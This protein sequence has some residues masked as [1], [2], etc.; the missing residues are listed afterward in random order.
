MSSRY[1]NRKR[2]WDQGDINDASNMSAS[3][4]EEQKS[5]KKPEIDPKEA[6]ALAAA[7]ANQILANKIIPAPENDDLVPKFDIV[8]D[9]KPSPGEG[10]EKQG[11]QNEQLVKIVDINDIPNRYQ[12]TKGSTQKNISE[13]TGVDISIKGR[14]YEDRTQATDDDPALYLRIE[15]T[16]QESLDRAVKMVEDILDSQRSNK[17]HA[18]R[19]DGGN[20]ESGYSRPS[21]RSRQLYQETVH[22][23]VE[24]ERGFNVRAKVIGS[25][26]ENMKFIQN[27]TGAKVQVKGMGSGFIET[28]L[29][30]ELPEP[31]HIQVTSYNEDSVKKAKEYCEDLIETIREDYEDFKKN[32]PP[33]RQTNHGR[34]SGGFGGPHRALTGANA[35]P[36]PPHGST[37]YGSASTGASAVAAPAAP[38]ATAT[39]SAPQPGA[40]DPNSAYPQNYTFDDYIAWLNHYYGPAA[41]AAAYNQ[42]AGYPGYPASSVNYTMPQ[43]TQQQLSHPSSMPPASVAKFEDTQV[44]TAPYNN[45]PPPDSLYG[46]KK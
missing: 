12:I 28:S 17:G 33:P 1:S 21:Y 36:T 13:S 8:V 42:Y 44:S 7:K 31:M 38:T 43:A 32:P 39:I 27:V 25:G 11:R 3:R 15:A 22:I 26:G 16:D 34:H 29:G 40:T 2:K 35:V 4:D 9:P 23:G 37:H 45:V 20:S 24:S 10:L 18:D 6:A 46:Q 41:A 19:T 14:Y 5:P 30:S